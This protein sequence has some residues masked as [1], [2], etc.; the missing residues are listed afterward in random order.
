MFF[1]VPRI[2]ISL[3][4]VLPVSNPVEVPVDVT[5]LD[6]KVNHV[7]LLNRLHL[8][9]QTLQVNSRLVEL[10]DGVRPRHVVR[11]GGQFIW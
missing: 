5:K 3:R 1:S 7:D 6:T 4:D 8:V 2:H 10:L 9:D 11:F